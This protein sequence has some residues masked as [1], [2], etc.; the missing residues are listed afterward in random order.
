[1]SVRVRYAPS[2]TGLQHIGSLRTALFNYFYARSHGG[3]CVLR[4]E[5]TDQSRF[6]PRALDDIYETF[7]WIG[8][9]FDEDPRQGGTFGP[10]IQSERRAIYSEHA[11]QLLEK[12]MAY[13]CFCSPDRLEKLREEQQRGG[14]AQGYDGRCRDLSPEACAKL[15]A[16]GEPA[17]IRFKLPREGQTV[18]QDEVLGATKRRH[19]DISPDPILLKSDGLPTY[20]LASVVDDHLMEISHIIRAQEWLSSAALH[21]LIYEAFGWQVPAFLHLPMVLGKDGKKLSKRHGA[22]SVSEFRGAGYLPEAVMNYVCTLGWSLEDREF[23]SREELEQLFA[24]GRINKAPAVFDYKKLL[25]YNA[26]YIRQAGDE[27]LTELCLP[28]LELPA[29]EAPAGAELLRRVMPLAKERLR[30]LADVSNV[31]GFLYRDVALE[32]GGE[33]LQKNQEAGQAL[34]ALR[35]IRAAFTTLSEMDDESLHAWFVGLA[36]KQGCG[37]G[38]VMLPLR[39]AL[40]GSKASPPL[41]D[42]IRLLGAETSLKRLDRAIELLTETET[43]TETEPLS[44]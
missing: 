7:R 35:A 44:S 22:A 3:V 41:A 43:E 39:V 37:P 2:P 30:T 13:K 31:L 14:L 33:L 12:D 38:R 9:E 23:F 36:E 28:W 21:Q 27:R 34:E 16:A 11:R 1:M 18:V 26:H 32:S 10:Y 42:C 25:W 15:D 8:V 19:R 29:P 4:I 24:R 40:T 20:H 5:D 6:D 17:V